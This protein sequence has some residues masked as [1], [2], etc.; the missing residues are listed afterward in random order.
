[1]QSWMFRFCTYSASHFLPV[2]YSSITAKVVVDIRLHV[3]QGFEPVSYLSYLKV[4]I[5][6]GNRTE[7]DSILLLVLETTYDFGPQTL[8]PE[9]CV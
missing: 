8:I 1:M 2:L 4:R 3:F 5:R 6:D 7:Y 9:P